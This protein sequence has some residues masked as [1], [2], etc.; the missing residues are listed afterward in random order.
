MKDVALESMAKLDALY[1][2]PTGM[3]NGDE[4]LPLPA[5]RHPSR[6]IELCGVVEAMFSYVVLF[7]TFGE[8]EFIDRATQIAFNALPATWASPS[9]YSCLLNEASS[10]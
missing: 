3:Y 8:T 5:T 1:G 6:G 7:Q 10:V 4:W 2:L 9:K